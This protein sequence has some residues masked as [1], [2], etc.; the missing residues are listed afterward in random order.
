MIK[1]LGTPQEV[2]NEDELKK[3]VERLGGLCL[4]FRSP[5]NRGVPDRICFL[6]GGR[7]YLAELKRPKKGL[8][9]LQKYFKKIFESLGFEV[10]VLDTKEK[11][12]Q[13]INAIQAI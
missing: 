5:G 13:F 10:H 6:P 9:P 7:L 12:K 3:A 2:D 8:D 1:N 11:I 4:K